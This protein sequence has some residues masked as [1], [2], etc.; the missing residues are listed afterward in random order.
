MLCSD[1]VVRRLSDVTSHSQTTDWIQNITEW[2]SS[3]QLPELEYEMNTAVLFIKST[4]DSYRV[5]YRW[6]HSECDRVG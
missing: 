4:S 1:V 2:K 5:I 3:M 6:Q